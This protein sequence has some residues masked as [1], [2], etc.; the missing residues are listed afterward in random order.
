LADDKDY[1]DKAARVSALARDV[2]EVM[3]ALAEPLKARLAAAGPAP[4]APMRVAFH[5]PC[6]LQHGLK[7]RGVVE[8][9]LTMAGF[10]LVP[11][12]DGHLCCGSAGT[13]SVLQAEI[14]TTL[15]QARL[16]AL[17]AG[18]PALIASANVGCIV[19]LQ[20]GDGPAVCHWVEL[21]D[22][23]LTGMAPSDANRA[24]MPGLPRE[25]S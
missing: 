6:T 19:H 12:A 20:D 21:I 16:A 9:L 23:R 2:S 24:T 4:G 5:A 7:L 17:S 15:R 14:A 8:P 13:Y 1:A 3:S 11:V 22:Q 18:R 10:E 25:P